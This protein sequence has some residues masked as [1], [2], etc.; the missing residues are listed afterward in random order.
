MFVTGQHFDYHFRGNVPFRGGR[1][2]LPNPA[3]L[4]TEEISFSVLFST[5]DG[6][7]L[8][9]YVDK[10][11]THEP[12]V[13]ALNRGDMVVFRYDCW[14]SGAPYSEGHRYRIHCYLESDRVLHE[15]GF[16]S[17]KRIRAGEMETIHERV[18][19]APRQNP[20]LNE[21]V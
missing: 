21:M 20:L 3:R 11:H 13:Y 16:F 14:H 10:Q 2:Y 1:R 6:A 12:T 9:V 7:L 5:S 8:P 18:E 19:L 17:T 15:K 4:F